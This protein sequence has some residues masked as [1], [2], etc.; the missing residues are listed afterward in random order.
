V[1]A[2]HALVADPRHLFGQPPQ[3]AVVQRRH[4]VALHRPRPGRLYPDLA[5][6]VDHDFRYVRP[7][8][9]RVQRR[10]GCRQDRIVDHRLTVEK[11]RSRA[12]NTRIGWPCATC[13]VGGICA[14]RCAATEAALDPLVDT[15]TLALLP[16][17]APNPL[18][19][20]SMVAAPNRLKK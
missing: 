2:V 18:I 20:D 7:R 1:R 12:V 9:E 5:W 13:T 19:T 16:A 10:E 17:S 4:G 8:Q 3:G 6:L 11:S 14:S 15:S